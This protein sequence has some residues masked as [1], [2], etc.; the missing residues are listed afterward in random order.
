MMQ[1]MLARGEITNSTRFS[2]S[3]KYLEGELH[4][5]TG[6]I[7]SV[8]ITISPIKTD[9]GYQ[10]LSITRDI[11]ERKRAELALKESENRYALAVLGAN[12]GI[13]DWNLQNNTIYY[14]PRW[15]AMLGYEDDEISDSPD[16]WFGRI[17]PEDIER[18]Q[19]DIS[20]HQDGHNPHFAS[21]HRIFHRDGFYRW[22]LARG[23]ANWDGSSGSSR[24][25]GSLSDITAR[26]A[27]E[28]RLRHD[29]MHDPL[30]GLP[31]RIYFMDQ[32]RRAID[33]SHRRTNYQAAILFL[34]LDRF[35]IVNDFLG[36]AI[37][38]FMLISIGERLQTSLRLGDTIARLG[39]DEFAILLD[40]I[41]GISDA[42]LVA[43]RLQQS[44]ELPFEL[45][46][47]EVFAT[48]SIGIA[49]T[50]KGYERAEDML[51]DADT[52]LYRAKAAGRARYAVFDNEMHAHNVEL[53]Q[54]EGEL[55]RAL[56]RDEFLLYYQPVVNLSSGFISSFEALIR[57]QHPLRG[58]ILPHE[59]IPLAEETGMIISIGEWVLRSAC[60]QVKVWT[61]MGYANVPVAVNISARQLQDQKLPELVRSIMDEVGVSPQAIHLEI[62]ETAA[63]QDITHTIQA[64]ESLRA[65]GVQFSIDDFGTNYSSLS[66]LQR[67]PVNCLKIDQS[68]IWD[69]HE[70]TD[71]S[72]I[73]TAIIAMGHLLNLKSNR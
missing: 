51:R 3:G 34:D 20:A 7:R 33:R 73:I 70:A 71:D 11:T 15:K 61:N 1:Q 14:S 27:T 50:S 41:S 40:D 57:W 60:K 72:G 18:V 55:R 67:F 23:Y 69:I 36:H 43:D 4:S 66:Y 30:T 39:G 19:A 22:V 42:I 25:A 10:L 46:G 12:D 8:Q 58:L 6:E 5:K 31:N 44:L 28:E 45:L 13:W 26:K 54:L 35:K 32:M 53:L 52:A 21:E 17:H 49:Q 48:V 64:L 68:F 37:G 56:E 47:H 62:T 29:A 16:E 2:N 59:F 63:M 65:Y 38:D 9:L 24:M